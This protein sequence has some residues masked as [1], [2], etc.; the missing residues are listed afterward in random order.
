MAGNFA[1]E[2]GLEKLPL[3][4]G[5]LCVLLWKG[6]GGENWFCNRL[7]QREALFGGRVELFQRKATGSIQYTDINSL[8]PYVM[9]FPFPDEIQVVHEWP[10]FGIAN[11]TID[12]PKSHLA[13]LPYR[14]PTE[15][16][17][18][19]EI[20]E[21]CTPIYYPTGRL[22]GTWTIHEIDNAVTHG[23]RIVEIHQMQG[24]NNAVR[25]YDDFVI[26]YYKMRLAAKTDSH[27]LMYKLLMNNLYGR[28]G[29]KGKITRSFPLTPEN[30][31]RAISV[32]G[33][34]CLVDCWTELSEYVNWLHAAYVTSYG[35]LTLFKYLSQID[36]TNLIYCDT[37]SAI[38]KGE[39]PY[40]TGSELGQMKIE[41]TYSNCETFAPKTYRV[42]ELAKAKGVPRHLAT[43]FINTS[44]ASFSL[45]FKLREAIRFYDEGNRKQLSAWR[46]VEKQKRSDYDKKKSFGNSFIPFDIKE[47][48]DSLA[49]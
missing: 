10:K 23:A 35:R 14:F 48:S 12:I 7:D 15:A 19:H 40:E 5:G 47:L 18:E 16:T 2:N 8:Y 29:M 25:Y 45:P 13:P 24:T 9:T 4:L 37:D 32:Y 11:V 21:Q 22:T 34:K 49:K 30:F 44:H 3:T 46:K 38:F 43:E 20:L 33:E 6:L 28:L 31:E 17:D 36:R 39:I 42:D 27:K 26:R 41:G 1:E